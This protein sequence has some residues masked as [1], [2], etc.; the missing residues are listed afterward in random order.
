VDVFGKRKSQR[1]AAEAQGVVNDAGLSG[2]GEIGLG[3]AEP[4]L[5]RKP[6]GI[7]ET[8]RIRVLIGELARAKEAG[9]EDAV[10]RIEDEIAGK[11][12]SPA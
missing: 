7:E 11:P 1:Q 8:R 3:G 4:E 2:A 5:P 10:R 9:D 12:G 6:S